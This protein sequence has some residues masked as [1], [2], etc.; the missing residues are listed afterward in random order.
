M[1]KK[2]SPFFGSLS[3]SLSLCVCVCARARLCRVVLSKALGGTL[4][5]CRQKCRFQK[6]IIMVQSSPLLSGSLSKPA[7]FETV[8]EKAPRRTRDALP[9]SSLLFSHQALAKK[10]KLDDVSRPLIC[11]PTTTLCPKVPA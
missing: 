7:L 6:G 3:L 2:V 8:V 10:K 1:K 4:S 5:F 9:L 11:S